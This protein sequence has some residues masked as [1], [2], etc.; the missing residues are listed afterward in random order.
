MSIKDEEEFDG[1][2]ILP[3]AVWFE[4][5]GGVFPEASAERILGSFQEMVTR[6]FKENSPW[7]YYRDTR[8]SI[9]AVVVTR[10][11]NIDEALLRWRAYNEREVEWKWNWGI[12]CTRIVADPRYATSYKGKS[13]D[14]IVGLLD[15]SLPIKQ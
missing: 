3:P 10:S 15:A 14:L 8:Y 6:F 12:D 13:Y 1:G 5:E 4:T 9:V 7:Q 2:P 11:D